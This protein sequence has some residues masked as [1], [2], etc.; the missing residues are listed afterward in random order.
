MKKNKTAVLRPKAQADKLK[1]MDIQGWA[2]AGEIFRFFK[3]IGEVG[4]KR[5][6][7]RAFSPKY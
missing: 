2:L 1:E 5:H 3:N 6:F 7:A 4:Q